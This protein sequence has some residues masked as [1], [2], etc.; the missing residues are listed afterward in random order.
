M[1]MPNTL[2]FIQ[3]KSPSI[4]ILLVGWASRY[5]LQMNETQSS[6]GDNSCPAINGS[7]T[8]A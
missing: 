8:A 1:P 6:V 4:S 2:F 7:T 3:Q 5:A